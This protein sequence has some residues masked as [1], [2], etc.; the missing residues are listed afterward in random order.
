MTVTLGAH[1][2]SADSNDVNR[3]QVF[4]LVNPNNVHSYPEWF[5]PDLE[6]D[7]ALIQ[8]PSKASINGELKHC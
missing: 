2:T 1:D 7:L 5:Y 4:Y 8:L 3:H 6:G